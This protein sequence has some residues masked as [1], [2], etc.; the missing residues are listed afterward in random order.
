MKIPQKPTE[1]WMLWNPTMKD[2]GIAFDDPDPETAYLC[3]KTKKAAKVLQ[4]HQK[5]LYE[6]NLIPVRVI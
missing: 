2:W 5:R 6:I 4:K 1:L 3:A